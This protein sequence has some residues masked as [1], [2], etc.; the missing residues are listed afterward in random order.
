MGLAPTSALESTRTENFDQV[1]FPLTILDTGLVEYNVILPR[2][3]TAGACEAQSKF[4]R[5]LCQAV[6]CQNRTFH[7][8]PLVIQ[9]H[10]YA[11]RI[12]LFYRQFLLSTQ[13][14]DAVKRYTHP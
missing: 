8:Q 14:H 7:V 10:K 13:A 4:L 5:R 9:G 1:L 12:V 6:Q 11:K 2:Y 3:L